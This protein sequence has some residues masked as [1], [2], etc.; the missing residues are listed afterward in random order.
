M[1]DEPP[2]SF[3][4]AEKKT[5]VHGQKKRALGRLKPTHL[6]RF[7]R[8]RESCCSR[9]GGDLKACTGCARHRR[10]RGRT[11]PHVGTAGLLSG[12]STHGLFFY[13]RAFRFAMRFR[14]IVGAA[15][16]RGA[17]PCVYR[18]DSRRQYQMRGRSS[19]V[20]RCI[21]HP[22]QAP[23]FCRTV[24]L[25]PRMCPNLPK[26]GFGHKSGFFSTAAAATFLCQD[27]EK[28]GPHPRPARPG[29]SPSPVGDPS[30]KRKTRQRDGEN[31]FAPPSW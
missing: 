26:G 5:A 16:E 25:D 6:C 3:R 4:L 21:A 17:D 20:L 28:W 23:L 11:L 19:T 2:F 18:P 9:C 10:T 15:A 7:D 30:L 31:L 13:A 22:V 8:K 24:S 12:W 1:G 27:K 14:E 29:T